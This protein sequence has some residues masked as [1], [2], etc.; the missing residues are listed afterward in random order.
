MRLDPT[1]P[2]TAST[3]LL[4]PGSGLGLSCPTVSLCVA[5]STYDYAFDPRGTGQ[6]AV[7]GPIITFPAIACPSVTHCIGMDDA[8]DAATFVPKPKR[9][10]VKA[11]TDVKLVQGPSPSRGKGPVRRRRR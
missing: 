2:A 10:T 4:G 7:V 5:T 6:P 3:T 8:G 11:D 1:L 9:R